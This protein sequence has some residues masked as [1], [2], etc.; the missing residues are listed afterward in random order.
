MT[1]TPDTFK[2]NRGLALSDL[3]VVAL[4]VAGVCLTAG[5]TWKLDAL[6]ALAVMLLGSVAIGLLFR[7]EVA[8]VATVFLLYVNFPAILTKQHGVPPAVAGAFILLLAFPIANAFV[9]RQQPLKADKPFFLMLALLAVMLLSSLGAVDNGIA[10]EAVTNY[11]LQGMVLYWLLVNAVRHV[12]D[13]RKVIWGVLAAGSLLGTLCLY[14]NVTGNYDQEFGG[15]AYRHYVGAASGADA[16]DD[17]DQAERRAS[18]DSF[19]AQGPV[20]QANRFAQVMIVLLPMAVYVYRTSRSRGSRMVA[21]GAGALVLTGVILTLSRGAF[22]TLAAMVLTMM[23][24]GWIRGSRVAI[25]AVLLALIIPAITPSFPDRME[26]IA[27][28][29]F[30]LGG[31]STEYNQADAAIRGRMTAMLAAFHVFLDHPV[32]GV[33]PGQYPP[34]YS[35]LYGNS[36]EAKFRDM[37]R[38]MRAH[39]LYLEL[40]AE[41]GVVGLLLFVAIAGVLVRDLWRAR[42]EWHERDGDRAD[43]ATALWLSL[44]TYLGMGVVEHLAFPRYYWFLVATASVV[45]HVIRSKDWPAAAAVRRRDSECQS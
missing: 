43:L 10:R 9:I 26:T 14:Q 27:N 35:Q 1:I 33:G 41:L 38:P 16:D 28:A 8:T 7:P 5:L 45:L 40:A 44:I 22:L 25:A 21:L 4:V 13:L 3:R 24:V 19:R 30:L 23:L 17:V 42:R 11:V 32:V 2:L 39:S 37:G 20:N 12:G 34:F 18:R 36:A 15:L 29:R 31:R 6:P